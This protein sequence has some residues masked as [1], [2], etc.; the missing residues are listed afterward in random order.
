MLWAV[1]V[2]GVVEVP[3]GCKGLG[4]PVAFPVAEAAHD[5]GDSVPV[6][7]VTQTSIHTANLRKERRQRE[8]RTFR[9]I[10]NEKEL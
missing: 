1:Q 10:L 9:P 2:E 3:V 7:V 5:G 4:V 6:A 8:K